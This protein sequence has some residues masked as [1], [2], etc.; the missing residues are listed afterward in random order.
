[1]EE[2]LGSCKI[3]SGGDGGYT[4]VDLKDTNRNLTASRLYYASMNFD[5]FGYL[6]GVGEDMKWIEFSLTGVSNP[7][8][9]VYVV[10]PFKKGYVMICIKKTFNNDPEGCYALLGVPDRTAA[11]AGSKVPLI[12]G[13]DTGVDRYVWGGIVNGVIDEDLFLGVS[14]SK[15]LTRRGNGTFN[16]TDAPWKMNT[17]YT[18]SP[19]MSSLSVSPS[20]ANL[21]LVTTYIPDGVY[22]SRDF[23]MKNINLNIQIGIQIMQNACMIYVVVIVVVVVMVVVVVAGLLLF[24]NCQRNAIKLT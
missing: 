10:N 6:P 11:P 1:M 17:L 13:Q 22:L 7:I 2:E 8:Q 21:A 18:S 9:P 24:S 4:A 14:N 3:Y 23:G 15:I 5:A 20:N 12:Q 16:S 19:Y